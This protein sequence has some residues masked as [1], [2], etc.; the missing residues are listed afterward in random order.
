[1]IDRNFVSYVSTTLT[2]IV[3]PPPVMDASPSIPAAAMYDVAAAIACAVLVWAPMPRHTQRGV[4]LLASR[5]CRLR[6][7][8]AGVLLGVHLAGQVHGHPDQHDHDE[9]RERQPDGD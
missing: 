2:V 3:V 7:D 4:D 5:T 6:G 1:M 9:R 8:V